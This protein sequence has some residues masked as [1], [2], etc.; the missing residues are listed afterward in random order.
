[1]IKTVL[2]TAAASALMIGG[3]HAADVEA[4]AAYDWSGFYVGL[5]AGY[6]W[7]DSQVDEIDVEEGSVNQTQDYDHDGFV[8]GVHAGYN[9]DMQGLLFGLEGD[10]EYADIQ[11]DQDFDGSEDAT[12]KTIEWLGSLRLR[13]GVTMDRALFYATGGVAAGDV[14]ME[15]SEPD[16][17]ISGS[18][19]AWGWTIG[20]GLEYALSDAISARVEYRY[21][22]LENTEHTGEIFGDTFTYEHENDF[23]AVRA[24]L[25]WHFN[26]M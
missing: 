6:G 13:A 18:E 26:S 2:M 9:F 23:H 21:T 11:G 12:D 24:G 22:D 15:A 3:A 25:S 8:G 16:L 1:M 5:Q 10:I 7:G 20:A 4:A 14:D 17:S 19:T